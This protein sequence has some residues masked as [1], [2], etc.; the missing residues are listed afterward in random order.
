MTTGRINQVTI[1]RRGWP[2]ALV[3]APERFPS[4][5]S[6]PLG[7][8]RSQRW[9]QGL[10]RLRR[11]SVFPLFVSQG[12][13]SPHQRCG[14]GCPERRTMHALLQPWRLPQRGVTP[15]CSLGR[16]SHRPSIHRAHPSAVGVASYRLR[17][18]QV[19]V[20]A[21]SLASLPLYPPAGETVACKRVQGDTQ[22]SLLRSGTLC[23]READLKRNPLPGPDCLPPS[24][25]P[26]EGL[27]V[28]RTPGPARG[29]LFIFRKIHLYG[30]T[31]KSTHG[32]TNVKPFRTHFFNFSHADRAAFRE[33][34]G[35]LHPPPGRPW[36]PPQP[37]KVLLQGRRLTLYLT[38]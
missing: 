3:T 36:R 24:H 2:P 31:K 26:S 30:K 5:W 18:Y 33:H 20:R 4:Y 27:L 1:V 15:R 7:A 17:A 16:S 28:G 37:A 9:R 34:N 11:Y 13:P 8:S 23:F 6:T 14:L 19:A 12:S 10:Q 22:R 21:G 32:H 29:P 35:M 38:T 25:I